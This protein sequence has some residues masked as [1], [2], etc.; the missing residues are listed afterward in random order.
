MSWRQVAATV[1][2]LCGALFVTVGTAAAQKD[3]RPAPLTPVTVQTLPAHKQAARPLPTFDPQKATNAYLARVSGEARKNSDSYFEGGYV[4]I[5]VDGLCAVA[6]AALLL[7][8]GF[9]AR[10]RSVAQRITRMRF[11]QV[12]IYVL[13]FVV[14]TTVLT[15]PLNVYEDF[16]RE[17]A[18]GLSNQNFAQ[19]FQ[20]FAIAF[21]VQLVVS[22]IAL[23]IIYSVIRATPRRWWAWGTVVTV[24]LFGCF[25]M[26]APVFVSPLFN[27]YY[28]LAESPIKERILS[29]A[30]ANGIPVDNV[31]EFDASKQSKR[32]SANVSGLFGTTR[33]SLNDN[34]MNRSSPREIVAVLG[35]EMGH[36]V[37]SHAFIGITWFGLVILVAFLFLNWGFRALVDVFGGNWDV[38]NID[39]PAGLP[40]FY[41]LIGIFFVLATPVTNTIS[42]TLEAQ[43]DIFGLNAARQP[44]GFA[45]ATLKLGEYR[46][47]D[48]TPLEEFVFYDHPSGRTRI[49]GAMRW[50]AWHL[51]DPDIKAGPVSPQ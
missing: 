38:R 2:I 42:R 46:K 35:H 16:F 13:M 19:W 40:V 18:Y 24:I 10:M 20:D 30:K 8:S 50:K 7:W 39:D 51:N 22:V 25:A 9:S 32:I 36:Y 49:F 4:L 41:A 28:P 23:T 44:D 43:A 29:L 17:H 47:L 45:T 26:A 31:Y 5:L 3:L 12:P 34:L 6:V 37:L 48:P 15:F 33:I 14:A 1:A 27:H 11:W 21:G